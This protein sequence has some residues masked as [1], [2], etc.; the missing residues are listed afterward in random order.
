MVALNFVSILR[1]TKLY[2][3]NRWIVWQVNDISIK[4]LLDTD[5]NWVCIRNIVLNIH[6]K[7]LWWSWSSN[8]LATWYEELIH[9]KRPWCWERLKAG[10]EGDD[11]GWDGWMAS[12]IRQTWVWTSSKS[13]WWTQKPGLLQSMESQTWLRKLNWTESDWT[14]LNSRN[15]NIYVAI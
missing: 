4:L 8:T 2:I 12:S 7:D 10:G 13:W 5:I 11:R 15:T 1:M 6:W 14:E 3:G 9:C